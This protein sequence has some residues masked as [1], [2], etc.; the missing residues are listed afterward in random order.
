[1][2]NTPPITDENVTTRS[3]SQVIAHPRKSMDRPQDKI[4]KNAWIIDKLGMEPFALTYS[5]RNGVTIEYNALC[6]RS[7]LENMIGENVECKS[8]LPEKRKYK[9]DIIDTIICPNLAP[10]IHRSPYRNMLM[11]LHHSNLNDDVAVLLNTDWIHVPHI[12]FACAQVLA[13][14]ILLNTISGEAIL[15]NTIEVYGRT[16]NVDIHRGISTPEDSTLPSSSSPYPNV[17]SCVKSTRDSRKLI[18]GTQSCSA[19]VTSSLRLDC[20]RDP[21]VDTFM[22]AISPHNYYCILYI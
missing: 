10:L 17:W 6:H 5:N 12:K 16:E 1:M 7:N 21:D 22:P 19:L 14:A 11:K 3:Y 9:S 4:D 2:K 20:E 18:I 15:L 13:G 8:L